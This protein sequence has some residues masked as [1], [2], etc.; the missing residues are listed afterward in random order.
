MKFRRSDGIEFDA[1]AG[2]AQAKMMQK[3]GGFELLDDDGKVDHEKTV[4]ISEADILEEKPK[5]K[6]GGGKSKN[7]NASA[8]IAETGEPEVE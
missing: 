1:D 4:S 8:D 3:D 2:S 6:S 5:G 7:K